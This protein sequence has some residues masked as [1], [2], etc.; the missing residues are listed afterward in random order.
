MRCLCKSFSVANPSLRVQSGS[1]QRYGLVCVSAC[2]LGSVSTI[3]VPITICHVLGVREI[4]WLSTALRT[5]CQWS[6]AFPLLGTAR[7]TAIRNCILIVR[8]TSR[9]YCSWQWVVVLL[10]FM[11]VHAVVIR[12]R[13]KSR[14]VRDISRVCS[15]RIDLLPQQRFRLC[16]RATMERWTALRWFMLSMTLLGTDPWRVMRRLDHIL[17]MQVPRGI[18]GE[19]LEM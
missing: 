4:P 5:S 17:Y 13:L 6:F 2:F 16:I 11:S 18:P 3:Q 15:V 14:P 7:Q 19:K 9:R 10:Q 12:G 1:V 8:S